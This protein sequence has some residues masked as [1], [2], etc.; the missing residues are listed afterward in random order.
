MN[1][2]LQGTITDASEYLIS[3]V[4]EDT[5]SEAARER[6]Q[7]LQ[8]QHPD[9]KMDLLWEEEVYAQSMHYDML[10]HLQG[11]GTVLLSFFP[12]HALPWTLHGVRCWSE[13]DL[14]QVNN[15]L[16]TIEEAIA[17]IDFIWDEAPIIKRLVDT[18]LIREALEKDLIE[19]SDAELQTAMNVFRKAR[20]LYRVE[21]T[22]RWLEQHGTTYE[23]LEQ[24]VASQAIVAK[25]RDRLTALHV[26][27]YF[28]EHQSD[29]DTATI[30]QFHVFDGESAHQIYEQ[31]QTGELDFYEAAQRHF[32]GAVGRREHPSGELF[33]VIQRGQTTSELSEAVFAAAPGDILPPVPTETG[34]AIA[35]VLSHH[36]ARLN[37]AT[38]STI[39]KILFEEWLAERR[40]EARIEWYWGTVQQTAALA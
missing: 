17:C 14:V 38:C 6:L 33:T 34:Y 10:L 26:A 9:T 32:L 29:F 19:L 36:P 8:K 21:D 15:T 39:K 25:L 16:L 30:A 40:Q 2:T 24:L 3:L 37:E 28:E 5:R 11:K 27:D 20:K 23:K 1:N 13:K 35:L 22:Y 18:C 31:I 7:L 4:E 12:N